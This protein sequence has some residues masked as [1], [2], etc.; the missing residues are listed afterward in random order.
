MIAVPVDPAPFQA[1]PVNDE[2]VGQFF[3]LGAHLREFLRHA[4]DTVG[5]LDARRSDPTDS[6]GGG[7]KRRDGCQGLGC[8]GDVA[9]VD[10]NAD[11][12][13]WTVDRDHIIVFFHYTSHFFEHIQKSDI[14]LDGIA[15]NIFHFDFPTTDSWSCKKVGGGR[16]VRFDRIRHT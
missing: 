12:G 6:C 5:F 8:V 7:S 16:G 2:A 13:R 15:R 14:P 11:D 1:I 3:D 9:H 10:V 4:L